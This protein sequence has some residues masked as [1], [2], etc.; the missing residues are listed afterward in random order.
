MQQKLGVRSSD[1]AV[2]LGWK[3]PEVFFG[4]LAR[5]VGGSIVVLSDD[6]TMVVAVGETKSACSLFMPVV[7][8]NRQKADS[9]WNTHILSEK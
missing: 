8:R 7:V 3:K 2:K 1:V 9:S 5:F 4:K 6:T